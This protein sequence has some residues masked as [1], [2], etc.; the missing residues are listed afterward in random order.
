[1]M[2]NSLSDFTNIQR[3]NK[4]EHGLIYKA[5]NKK[6]NK[7]YAIKEIKNNNSKKVIEREKMLLENV[8]HQNII[9]FYSS[10]VEN[11]INYFVLE[12][13]DGEDL[14]NLS[15]KYKNMNPPQYIPQSLIIIILKGI[16][17]GLLYLHSRNI[18][19]RDITPDNI[20]IDKNYV[21]KITDFGISKICN[22]D[23]FSKGTIVGKSDYASPEI[24]KAFFYNLDYANYN[25]KTDVFSLGVTMFYIMTFTLPIQV[26]QQNKTFERNDNFINPNIYHRKLIDLVESMLIFDENLRPSSFDLYNEMCK[27]IGEEIMSSNYHIKHINEIN[28]K[29]N[30]EI[31]RNAFSIVILY[32]NK[33][34][35]IK[36]Y[37]SSNLI[38][39]KIEE[40][41]KK[42]PNLS[43]VINSFAEVLNDF[44]QKDNRLNSITKFI[45]KISQKIL[46][47]KEEEEIKITPRLI[48]RKLFEYFYFVFYQTL[49]T[50]NYNN[51]NAYKLYEKLKK[52]PNIDKGYIE[53]INEFKINYANIFSGTYYF[54]ILKRINCPN[55][56]NI[57]EDRI[58]IIYDID[59]PKYGPIN[60]LLEEYQGAKSIKNYNSKICN[61][62]CVLPTNY[63]ETKSLI[64]APNILIF[65]FENGAKLEEYIEIKE[66]FKPNEKVLYKI[67]TIIILSTNNI[68]N[69]AIYNENISNWMYYFDEKNNSINN[70]KEVIEKGKVFIA[71][72]KIYKDEDKD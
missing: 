72:Y 39:S 69:V 9:R 16:I 32:F 29:N 60:Q 13:F 62:C 41:E 50:F 70:F 4:G 7:I 19:H 17:N 26:N 8:S 33:E 14:E 21:V 71:F 68:Y 42:S 51:K 20:M 58:E 30:F 6:D 48:I 49:D 59:F 38:R 56:N 61:K 10:F 15:K 44:N 43:F 18:M 27:L 2:M 23:E 57:I 36:D 66:Y 24:Y 64:I 52:M 53:K 34:E 28:L 25:F 55:C 63:I 45:I 5:T 31:I 22:L 12:F 54:P 3:I 65:N 47:F 37:F 40:I 1:M 11:N 67:N 46:I 35:I